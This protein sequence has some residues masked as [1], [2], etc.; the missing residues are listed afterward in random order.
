MK[1]ELIEYDIKLQH[2]QNDMYKALEQKSK[3]HFDLITEEYKNIMEG[4]EG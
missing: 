2:E 3:D 4:K 1:T